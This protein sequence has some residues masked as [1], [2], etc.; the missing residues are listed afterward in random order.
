MQAFVCYA[1]KDK[2]QVEKLLDLLHPRFEIATGM[3]LHLWR[4]QLI[5]VGSAWRDEIRQA[6]RACD[7]GL[8]MLSPDF[9]ASDFITREELPHLLRQLNGGLQLHKPVVPIVVKRIPLDG[10]ADTQGVDQLQVFTDDQGRCFSQTRGHIRDAF[11]D[12]LTQAIQ[13]RFA[14]PGY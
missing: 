11:A 3:N 13:S 2:S 5:P 9:F 14:N 7:L 12:Q 8:L 6:L 4:D 10:A 1:R